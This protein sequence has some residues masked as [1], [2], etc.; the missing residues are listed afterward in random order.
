MSTTGEK[1][2]QNTNTWRPNSM[3]L[4]N[5]KVTKETKEEN[6]KYL[7]ANDNENTIQNLW[8]ATE[9]VLRG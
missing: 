8:N 3:L 6:K 2:V 7:K 4:I 1:T 5:P 9:V